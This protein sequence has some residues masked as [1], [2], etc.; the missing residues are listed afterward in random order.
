MI[1]FYP[2]QCQAGATRSDVA[3]S[4]AG[5]GWWPKG[6]LASA[7]P[8]SRGDPAGLPSWGH[9]SFP[10]HSFHSARANVPSCFSRVRL[11][12]TPWTLAHL[13]PLSM[14]LSREEYPSGCL[15][16]LQGIFLIQG[17]NPHLLRPLHCRLILH[18]QAAR[19]A[20]PFPPALPCKW[21]PAYGP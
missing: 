5:A 14:G 6:H 21:K 9:P 1:R 11:F 8:L 12:E 3:P 15:S 10:T 13:A 16:L 7:W 2:S 20:L 17:S 4:L 19:K 18:G